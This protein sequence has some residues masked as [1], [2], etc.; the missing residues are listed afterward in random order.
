MKP[1]GVVMPSRY[2][3]TVVID[4][5]VSAGTYAQETQQICKSRRKRVVANQEEISTPNAIASLNA[6]S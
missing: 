6:T 2:Q 3:A 1:T 4:L 5:A